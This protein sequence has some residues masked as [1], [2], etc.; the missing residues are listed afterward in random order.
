MGY[1]TRD[2]NKGVRCAW[3]EA[4]WILI[5]KDPTMRVKYE[6][7]R[8]RRGAKRAIIAVVRCLSARIKRIF[9]DQASCASSAC[10][11]DFDVAMTNSRIKVDI[12]RALC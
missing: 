7:I 9:F 4:S 10:P 6:Y 1:I 11:A 8:H 2:G 3:V 12:R 5:G